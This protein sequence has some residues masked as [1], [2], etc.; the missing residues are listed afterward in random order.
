LSALLVR[1]SGLRLRVGQAHSVRGLAQSPVAGPEPGLGAPRNGRQQVQVDADR[2]SVLICISLV[3]DGDGRP[4]GSGPAESSIGAGR[5]ARQASSA[6][7]AMVSTGSSVEAAMR[8]VAEDFDV[9]ALVEDGKEPDLAPQPVQ[10][11]LQRSLGRR[12]SGHLRYW[13]LCHSQVDHLAMPKNTA[14]ARSISTSLSRSIRPNTG[15]TLSRL[16]VIA[17]STMA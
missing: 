12:L 6:V 8:V 11:F 15:P 1:E 17:L 13:C 7:R 3:S 5:R 4:T 16:T 9:A 10:G 2:L 14:R